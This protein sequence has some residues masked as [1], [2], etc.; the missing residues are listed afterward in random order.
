[1]DTSG[2][3]ARRGRRDQ[4]EVEPDDIVGSRARD[5]WQDFAG[6]TGC[7]VDPPPFGKG[8]VGLLLPAGSPAAALDQVAA[9]GGETALV[10]DVA[11]AVA[12]GALGQALGVADMSPGHKGFRSAGPVCCCREEQRDGFKGP[13]ENPPTLHPELAD[14]VE[15]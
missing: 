9:A 8:G 7:P 5:R 14:A 12:G 4:A 1:M 11:R 13:W 15:E 6:A 3:L 10:V 2:P